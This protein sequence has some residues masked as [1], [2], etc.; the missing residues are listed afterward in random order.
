MQPRFNHRQTAPELMKA[1]VAL[2]TA[3]DA[4]G[5]E[6]PLLHLVKLRASQINGCAYC[7]DKHARDARAEGE[8]EQRIVMVSAWRESPAFS[9]RERAAL[10]WT[11]SLT[12][13]ART[14]V[15]DADYEIV[16]AEFTEHE[17]AALTVLIGMIN[18]WNRIG[19]SARLVHPLKNAAA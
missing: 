8:S 2:D 4:A 9:K 11:E 19:V 5:L 13:V 14:G 15:P 7:V 6:K 16:S 17:V 10:A 12:L 1:V 3:V 18:L